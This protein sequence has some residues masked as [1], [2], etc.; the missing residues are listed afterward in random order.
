MADLNPRWTRDELIL[1][2][3][4]YFRTRGSPPSATD[5][6]IIELSAL[7]NL[8]P[9]HAQRANKKFRNP[10]GVA[11]KLANFA[12]LDPE[13][14]GV[15]LTRGSRLD[16]EVWNEFSADPLRLRNDALAIRAFS[17]HSSEA[18]EASF[19]EE[20]GVEGRILM[21]EH[22]ARER[23]GNLPVK[24]KAQ[25]LA[26]FGAL[27]CE[28]CDFDYTVAYGDLGYGFIE[29]HHKLPLSQ[30]APDSKTQLNDLV[31]VCASCHRMLHRQSD[32]SDLEGLRQ[33]MAGLG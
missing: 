3:D 13:Y 21:R 33:R 1:A 29:C 25:A 14:S 10:N 11:M 26:K 15:G 27:R 23:D 12:R 20:E 24:K 2:L 19:D 28:V 17:E 31:L 6:Q 30:L 8:L 22:K 4:L 16:E 7:L 5:P 32:P 9:I 18:E